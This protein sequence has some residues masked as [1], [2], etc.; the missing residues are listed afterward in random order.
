MNSQLQGHGGQQEQSKVI[1]KNKKSAEATDIS[2]EAASGKSFEFKYVSN[3]QGE[4]HNS[5]SCCTKQNRSNVQHSTCCDDGDDGGSH[6]YSQYHQVINQTDLMDGVG[7]A[8]SL[9]TEQYLDT[10]L[11]DAV[12]GGS[13]SLFM[14]EDRVGEGVPMLAV[15]LPSIPLVDPV[16]PLI[17]SVSPTVF[18]G[19]PN[20]LSQDDEARLLPPVETAFMGWVKL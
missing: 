9:F 14:E 16:Q 13:S 8:M 3:V 18:K 5:S 19:V 6:E 1:R 11:F 2:G 17:S 4:S 20:D 15:P 12:G 10:Y 7:H